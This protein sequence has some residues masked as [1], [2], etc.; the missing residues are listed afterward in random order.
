VI[1]YCA[2]NIVSTSS[3]SL[4]AFTYYLSNDAVTV[5]PQS[6][7][8]TTRTSERCPLTYS[9]YL[10]NTES[11]NWILQTVNTAPINAFNTITG[12]LSIFTTDQTLAKIYSIKW[13]IEDPDSNS[14]ASFVE[15]TFELTVISICTTNKITVVGNGIDHQ[16]YYLGNE[17]LTIRP[18]STFT[19]SVDAARCPLTFSYYVNTILQDSSTAPFISFSA[20]TGELGVKTSDPALAKTY[21]I[22][23]KIRDPESLTENSYADEIFD[24]TIVSICS[25]NTI[26]SDGNRVDDQTYYLGENELT[27]KPKST[28]IT[29]LPVSSCPLTFSYYLK[30]TVTNE[31]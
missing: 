28:I 7:I 26:A 20:L 4:V 18:Q 14:E 30:N 8:T 25:T 10:M 5:S 2:S 19:T 13:R 1:H 21:S 17:Q 24:L 6:V 16:N 31:W 29:K 22:K 12:D 11:S 9:Y 23:L 15:V 27:V 3:N